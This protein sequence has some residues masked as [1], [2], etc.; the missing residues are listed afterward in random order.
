MRSAARKPRPPHRHQSG[1]RISKTASRRDLTGEVAGSGVTMFLTTA[2]KPGTLREVKAARLRRCTSL[3]KPRVYPR[4]SRCAEFTSHRA[5]A[6]LPVKTP[7]YGRTKPTNVWFDRTEK[8]DVLLG[9][10]VTLGGL[11]T[12]VSTAGGLVAQEPAS[13]YAARPPTVVPLCPSRWDCWDSTLCRP[14][15]RLI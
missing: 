3:Y 7:E 14:I 15:D 9:S 13:M 12:G 5:P 1:S 8:S 10:K 11:T 4:S 2:Q 6:S